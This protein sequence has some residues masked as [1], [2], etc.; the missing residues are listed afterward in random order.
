[1][2]RPPH[3]VVV[4][5]GAVGGFYSAILKQAGC[6]VSV[7]LRSAYDA[8]VS[9]GFVIESPLG[10]LS[11]RPDFIYRDG[12]T[13]ADS[14]APPP[15]YVLICV[16]VLP[17]VSRAELARPWVGSATRLVLIENGIDIEPE[18][19]QAFPDNPLISCSAFVAVAG[20]AP[21]EIKHSAHGRLIAGCF[22]EGVDSH[23]RELADLFEAGGITVKLSESIIKDRWKKCVWNTALNP[24]AVLANGADTGTMLETPG[25]ETLVRALMAEVCAVASADGYPLSDAIIDANIDGTRKMASFKNSMAQDYLNGRPIELDAILGNVVTI[26]RRHIVPVPLLETLLAILRMRKS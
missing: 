11:Y 12:A 2:S 5:A 21:G 24:L 6:T 16:K 15:D 18:L 25:G 7:V 13:T 10:D 9:H 19:A 3:V 1:M 20:V 8:V 22:P 4:G 23:C 26:A 14:S 17:G